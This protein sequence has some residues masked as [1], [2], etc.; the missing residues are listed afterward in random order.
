MK[1]GKLFERVKEL[2]LKQGSIVL[3][4]ERAMHWCVNASPNNFNQIAKC[5]T[6]VL[7]REDYFLHQ[8]LIIV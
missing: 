2:G 8:V 3:L 1:D 4:L 7:Q 6:F 5:K